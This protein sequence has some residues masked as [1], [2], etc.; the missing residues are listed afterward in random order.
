MVKFWAATLDSNGY[1]SNE[2]S[3]PLSSPIHLPNF[4]HWKGCEFNCSSLSHSLNPKL[5]PYPPLN[6]NKVSLGQDKP[7]KMASFQIFI[8]WPLNP[9]IV[10][11]I[12][13]HFFYCDFSFRSLAHN[14]LEVIEPNAFHGLKNLTHLW[15]DIGI[16]RHNHHLEFQVVLSLSE[17]GSTSSLW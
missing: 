15:V 6:V 10:P 4:I 16:Y 5:F 2:I 1:F 8:L 3:S 7:T 17:G 9:Q 11:H 14:R 13:D 12:N